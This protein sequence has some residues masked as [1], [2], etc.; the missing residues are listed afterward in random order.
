[1][2]HIVSIN[3]VLNTHKITDLELLALCDAK[4]SVFPVTHF[5][6]LLTAFLNINVLFPTWWLGFICQWL[7]KFISSI[8]H[9]NPQKIFSKVYKTQA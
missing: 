1:M 4:P 5:F 9:V 6:P 3:S 7:L 2:E 8:L